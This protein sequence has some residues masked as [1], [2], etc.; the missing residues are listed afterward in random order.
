M[1]KLAA[2]LG[3]A[4]LIAGVPMGGALAGSGTDGHNE[5]PAMSRK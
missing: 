2:V 3:A 5:G 1:R 4:L